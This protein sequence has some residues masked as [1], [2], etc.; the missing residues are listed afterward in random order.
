M[1]SSQHV[2]GTDRCLEAL[3][4]L[5][6][7]FDVVINIQGDEPFIKPEQIKQVANCFL[8]T[9]TQ[10]AT[11]AKTINNKKELLDTNTTKVILD[12]NK[13]ALSFFRK[14]IAKKE[15]NTKP[16][17]KHIGI[18][19]YRT[20]VLTEIIK[21]P[22]SPNEIS[23]RLEQLRWLEKGYK[24]KIAITDIE[25]ISIDTPEDLKKIEFLR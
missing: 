10:I 17:F 6:E 21:L 11:L 9:K 16:F 7:K 13:T 22:Q 8:N 12:N 24:I 1:T 4:K 20:K 14:I 25:S 5:N 2:S 15:I 18:Y 3:E 23:E 19:G